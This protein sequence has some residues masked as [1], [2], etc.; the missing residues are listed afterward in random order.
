MSAEVLVYIA[1]TNIY[2]TAANDAA[3]RLRFE[4]F[5]HASGVLPVSAVVAAEVLLGI[6]NAAQHSVALRAL[7]AGTTVA[8]P[9]P[10]DWA[11]AA[12]AVVQLGGNVV[13][14][15]RSF[16]NDAVLAAQCTRLGATLITHNTADFR[17]LGRV[18]D[19]RAVP[20]FP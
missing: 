4:A 18:L 2:V 20:P 15:S 10:E 12:T 14:K 17:R 6:A 7:G 1:D 8:A 13:T 3:F 5:I 16:W 11:R 19:V 9:H